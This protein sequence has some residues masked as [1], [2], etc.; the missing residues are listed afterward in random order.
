MRAAAAG[1]RTGRALVVEALVL[2]AVL[3]WCLALLV[4]ALSVAASVSLEADA[5]TRAATAAAAAAERFCADPSS[6]APRTVE[7]DL[8]VT[9]ERA[10]ER[11]GEGTLWRATIE[12]GPV[13]GPEGV[14]LV[15]L[16]TARFEPW[17]VG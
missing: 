16:E 3:S 1:R 10:Q 15:S 14:P 9:V 5:R 4:Q 2:M 8:A 6:V 17:G 11:V 7:G 13:D 12:V